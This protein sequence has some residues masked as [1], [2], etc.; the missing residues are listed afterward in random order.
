MKTDVFAKHC[1]IAV[2]FFAAVAFTA[3]DDQNF[4]WEKAKSENVEYRYEQNFQKIFGS[5]DP[6]QNWDLSGLAKEEVTSFKLEDGT[7]VN[8]GDV[9]EKTAATRA[10]D[11]FTN[12]TTTTDY[13]DIPSNSLTWFKN[14]WQDGKDHR[15]MGKPFAMYVPGGEC[16][17]TPFFQGNAVDTWDLKIYFVVPDPTD[18]NKPSTTY[19]KTVWSKGD[20][21][22]AKAKKSDSWANVGNGNTEQSYAVR[23]KTLHFTN[24]PKGTIV[25]FGL[26]DKSFKVGD[27]QFEAL[28]TADQMRAITL[29][30]S[31]IPSAYPIDFG[32]YNHPVI[33]GC[34]DRPLASSDKDYNDIVFFVNGL[35][36]QTL[37][38]TYRTVTYDKRYMVE[39]MGYSDKNSEAV[40]KGY[41][42]IDFNDIV[43]D[44]HK[45][46][47]VKSTWTNG[48]WTKDE[49]V[50]IQESNA[51]VRALGGTWDFKLFV[52]DNCVFQ[53]SDANNY[54]NYNSN[55]TLTNGQRISSID[56]KTMYNV[57]RD[58]KMS[59]DGRKVVDAYIGTLKNNV[60]NWNPNENN[61]RF[62]IIDSGTVGVDYGQGIKDML[63]S[64]TDG[65]NVYT[66]T[67]PTMGATPKIAAFPVT[68]VWNNER[69]PVDKSFFS[70]SQVAPV[71]EQ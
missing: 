56:V 50:Q 9:V 30:T 51:K 27:A 19:S 10:A 59:G 44:F 32:E 4:D 23:S 18:A 15:D 45:K 31:A 1:V 6:E 11:D 33:M 14:N 42:D 26:Y 38:Y 35:F 3:C 49:E 34:E 2:T 41:T 63:N 61:I 29:P 28:S 60:Q 16:S 66:I 58:T 65:N 12:P 25:Y 64:S 5:I 20:L 69:I 62:E 17:I 57:G 55:Y 13:Y 70:T 22:Q 7:V 68:K 53:K 43:I 71:V 48:L 39:D 47:R 8:I 46:T 40:S 24:I 21:M 54:I 52:G 37:E 67:W 36:P